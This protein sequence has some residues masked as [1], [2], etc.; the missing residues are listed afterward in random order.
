MLN[1]QFP[2]FPFERHSNSQIHMIILIINQ[3]TNSAA[4]KIIRRNTIMQTY[5][6]IKLQIEERWSFAV[7]IK[8]NNSRSIE[9]LFDKEEEN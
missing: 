8:R 7:Q 3:T 4:Y 2:V 1:C 9:N 6:R 5:F